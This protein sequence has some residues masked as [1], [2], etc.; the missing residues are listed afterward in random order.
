MCASPVL[1]SQSNDHFEVVGLDLR[2]VSYVNE[3]SEFTLQIAE[4]YLDRAGLAFPTRILISLRPPEHVHFAGNYRIR[5]AER[6]AVQLDLRWEASTTL[7][8]TC[9]AIAEVLLVQYAVFNHG[10][11]AGS[12]LRAW[13]VSALGYD[14]FHSLRP[15]KFIDLVERTRAGGLPNFST[16]LELPQAQANADAESADPA[17][18]YWLL[19]AMKSSS[20]KRPA[21]RSLFKQAV[22]GIDIE[23]SLNSAVQPNE[24]TAALLPVQTWWIGQMDA[25]LSREYEVIETMQISRDWLALL[26]R[27]SAPLTLESEAVKLNLR[28]LWTHR[29]QPQVRELVQA[30]YEILLLRMSRINPAYFN[31]ARSLGVLYEGILRDAPSHQHIHALA[32][33][34]S[35]WEDAK[36]MQKEIEK[37]LLKE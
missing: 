34:L 29:A 5:I 11:A 14:I 9:R 25:L 27:F 31:P 30:R 1:R 23:D 28:S 10:T 12:Q 37:I 15:A 18:G 17:A 26:A 35:D 16:L 7:E 33:Y 32:I 24:P 21:I 8:Q 2:S 6:G 4:R 36:D 22:A 19:E 20:L 3:L 13:P